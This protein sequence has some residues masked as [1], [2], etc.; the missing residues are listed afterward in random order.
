MGIRA[1]FFFL[2]SVGISYCV[3]DFDLLSVFDFVELGFRDTPNE[4]CFAPIG[5]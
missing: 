1:D 4:Y 2:L 3:I 5:V